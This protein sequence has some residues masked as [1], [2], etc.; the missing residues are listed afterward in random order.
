MQT[1]FLRLPEL[2]VVA[3]QF[4]VVLRN[5]PIFRGDDPEWSAAV[6]TFP[7]TVSQKRALAAL[8]DREFANADYRALNALDRDAAYAELAEL[9]ALGHLTAEGSGAGT[10]YRVNRRLPPASVEQG[11]LAL[12]IDRMRAA[13]FLRN[14]DYRAAV[15]VDERAAR[16][17]F[18]A[19]ARVGVVVRT[20]EKRGTRYAPGQHWP[21]VDLPSHGT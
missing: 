14:S 3:G 20:G 2:D 6:R 9:V 13:G 5:E 19:W 7:L 18:A 11:P 17:A 4:Q 15:G 1:S 16:L 21:P 10:R 12:L 8:T